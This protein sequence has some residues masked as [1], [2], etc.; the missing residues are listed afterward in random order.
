MSCMEHRCQVCDWVTFNNN[1]SMGFCPKCG[2]DIISSYDD[3]EEDE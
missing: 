3:D 1:P 2:E